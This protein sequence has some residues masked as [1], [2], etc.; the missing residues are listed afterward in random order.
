[1]IS[2]YTSTAIFINRKFR[3]N[4][5]TVDKLAKELKIEKKNAIVTIAQMCKDQI[6]V[7]SV[8]EKGKEKFKIDLAYKLRIQQLSDQ[9][10]SLQ[11]I[12]KELE[13][14]ASFFLKE[15]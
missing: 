1:M 15:V 9:I 5:F 14:K 4:W 8:N 3:N 12:K 11:T 2:E 10:Q 7:M 13:R 6:C